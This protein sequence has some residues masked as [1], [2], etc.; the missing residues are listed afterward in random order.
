MK[1]IILPL[2]I[3]L[4]IS[5]FAQTN[6]ELLPY[7]PDVDGN[8]IIGSSDLIGF[9]PLYGE[10]FQ[11]DGVLPIELGGTGETSITDIRKTLNI[12]AF[13]DD[14]LDVGI[15]IGG[16]GLPFACNYD[17]AADY[18]IIAMCD[19]TSCQGCTN[20][21]ACNYDVNSYLD[22]GS[23]ILPQIGYD[24]NGECIDD[25]NDGICDE[26]EPYL[27]PN[28]NNQLAC[29][30]GTP[31]EACIFLDD[32]GNVCAQGGCT[33]V[34]ALNYNEN[35]D[36]NDGSCEYFLVGGIVNGTFKVTETFNHGF[37]NS[38]TGAYAQASGRNNIASGTY[39][40]ASNQNCS[41]TSIC[42]SAQNEGT[43]ASGVASH[44]EGF[45]TLASGFSSHAE[46]RNTTASGDYSH[47]QGYNTTASGYYSHAQGRNSEAT[48]NATTAIGY[49]VVADQENSLVVGKYN[50]ENREGTLFVVGDGES[51]AARSNAFEVSSDGALVNGD[52]VVSGGI[53][54][55]GQEL[56]QIIAGL[57]AQIDALQAEI[58]GMIGGE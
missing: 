53:S 1:K 16:C 43:T 2:F 57:Q 35:A 29:N 51:D 39:S 46:G 6:N 18:T 10:N 7:N 17:L 23:C 20:S 32:N 27:E 4:S 11:A 36:F 33:I 22:D 37:G 44:A 34:G 42:A 52:L 5:T 13:Q 41:A 26:V 55:D 12:S 47:A 19:F 24:C 31:D 21:T 30:F 56:L 45:T 15:Q 9:L 28:C 49:G 25:D 48:N 3:L 40:F 54:L 8:G 14:T 58:D 50:E 38:V